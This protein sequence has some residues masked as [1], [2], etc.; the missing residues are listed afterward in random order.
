MGRRI[1]NLGDYNKVRVDLQA[2]SGSINTLYSSI[3][4]IAVTKA[5][6]KLL[7]IGG[8]ITIGLCYAGN[9]T[10]AFLKKRKQLIEAEPQLKIEFEQA[11]SSDIEESFEEVSE[12][13]EMD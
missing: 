10:V 3:G 6:P 11:L 4:K 9:K 5:A 12:N 13:G 7:L 1:E 2:A 8:A